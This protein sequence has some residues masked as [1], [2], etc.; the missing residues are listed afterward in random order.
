MRWKERSREEYG[1]GWEGAGGGRDGGVGDRDSDTIETEERGMEIGEDVESVETWTDPGLHNKKLSLLDAT[2]RSKSP[3][4]NTTHSA[5][6]SAST[7][8]TGNL[9]ARSEST[10][11]GRKETLMVNAAILGPRVSGKAL[12]LN[13]PIVIDVDVPVWEE[14]RGRRM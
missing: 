8:N 12:V 7:L 14:G 1:G 11:T 9:I 13:K 2:S 5:T 4:Q 3:L 6:H 10:F